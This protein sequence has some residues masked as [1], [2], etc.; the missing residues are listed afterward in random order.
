V[1]DAAPEGP[2][3]RLNRVLRQEHRQILLA[4]EQLAAD[5]VEAALAGP[6]LPAVNGSEQHD[7]VSAP[8]AELN[9]HLIVDVRLQNN[10]QPREDE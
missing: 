1:A 8:T 3:P 10:G 9:G 5:A 4:Q 2:Q 6:A 7:R